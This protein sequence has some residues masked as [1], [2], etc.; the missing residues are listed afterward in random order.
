MYGK[1]LSAAAVAGVTCI[2]NPVTAARVVLEK[3]DHD[4]YWYGA[5]EFAKSHGLETAAPDY[6]FAQERWEALEKMRKENA[7]HMELD[8]GS[9][10]ADSKKKKEEKF[11]TVGAVALDSFGNLA[12]ATSTGGLTNKKWGRI[13]GLTGNWLGHLCQSFVCGE[14][15]GFGRVFSSLVRCQNPCRPDGIQRIFAW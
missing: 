11:G 6:F 2:K 5:E 14:L 8:H 9:K 3:S 10:K 1:N 13:G 12:A 4:A 7:T 15:Y